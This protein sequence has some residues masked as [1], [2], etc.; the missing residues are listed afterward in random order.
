MN[1]SIPFGTLLQ[2]FFAEH[3]TNQRRVSPHT[4]KAYRDSLRLLLAYLHESRGILPSDI[5]VV[6]LDA[7]AILD[8]L[9]HLERV[10]ACSVRSRNA[11][12]AAIRAFFRYTALR[13]PEHVAV[14]TRILAIPVKRTDR[15]LVGYLTREE[16]QAVLAAPDRTQWMGRRDHALLLIFYNTGARLSEVTGLKRGDVRFD[17]RAFVLLHGK[18]RKE[19]EVPLWA[20]TARTLKKWL[21][22]NSPGPGDALFPSS[23]GGLLSADS[24]S[25]IVRVAVG[26]ASAKCPSLATK[27]VTP[28]VFRHSTAMH[29]LQSGVDISV[30]ALW[31]GHESIETTHIYVEADLATKERALDMLAPAG[32]NPPRFK[33]SDPVLTF[34]SRL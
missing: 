10:R 2:A 29:L 27:R 12:L 9:D 30:I 24:V 5:R 8:F 25:H 4:V 17:T 6:D 26:T 23:R 7:P 13:D 18:G 3:L 16:V 32:C 28:H 11:R 22:E 33:P 31:L 21:E 20:N 34:L 1:A 14:A 19:R 15:R